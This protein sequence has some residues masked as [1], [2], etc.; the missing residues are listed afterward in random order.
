MYEKLNICK[1]AGNGYQFFDEGI[2]KQRELDQL[3]ASVAEAGTEP[4]ILVADM[5]LDAV[6]A[7]RRRVPALDHDRAFT[8]PSRDDFVRVAS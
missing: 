7:A 4:G 6:R 1:H 8:G 3:V 5:D 2:V